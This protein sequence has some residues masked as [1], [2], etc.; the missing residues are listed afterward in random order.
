LQ[1]HIS[2]GEPKLALDLWAGK[3]SAG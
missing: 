3:P 2:G 1:P